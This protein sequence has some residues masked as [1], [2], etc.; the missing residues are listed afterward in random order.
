MQP[1]PAIRILNISGGVQSTALLLLSAQGKIER[2]D[3][4]VFADNGWESRK[5]HEALDRLEREVCVPAGIPLLRVVTGDMRADC[6]DPVRGFAPIPLHVRKADGSRTLGLRQCSG[7]YK[8]RP[9]LRVARNLLGA[10]SR[11]GPVAGGR[12]AEMWVGISTD[13]AVR[14]GREHGRNYAK[15]RWPLLE[16]GLSRDDCRGVNE[17]AGFLDV[18]KTSCIGC[19]FRTDEEWRA[20][21]DE[22]PDEWADAVDFDARIRGLPGLRSDAFLHR[23]LVPLGVAD[24]DASVR[25]VELGR[26]V[27]RLVA[28]AGELTVGQCERLRAAVGG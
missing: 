26:L 4:A 13:E 2:V 21:R 23:S 22:C 16:L 15:Y 5:V 8:K 19:P 12:W 10:S 6:L 9:L 24:I 3:Y 20:L 1:E 28:A 27:S 7:E 11:Y 17:A 14:A 18:P 25:E